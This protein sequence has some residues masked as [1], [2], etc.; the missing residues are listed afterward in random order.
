MNGMLLMSGRILMLIS[1]LP[2]EA[3]SS[4]IKLA[5][6]A[7]FKLTAASA[8]PGGLV[9]HAE[10]VGEE[11]FFVPELDI[12]R[13]EAELAHEVLAPAVPRGV[14]PAQG[15]AWHDLRHLE[16]FR[17]PVLHFFYRD[18]VEYGHAKRFHDTS[19]SSRS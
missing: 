15:K 12:G 13:Q 3:T 6:P 5:V 9:V 7:P 1:P 14:Y 18:Q 8:I 10:V 4:V 19:F 11:P 2:L 16:R 17:Y